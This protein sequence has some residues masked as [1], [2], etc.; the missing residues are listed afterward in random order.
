MN[1]TCQLNLKLLEK[2]KKKLYDITFRIKNL[3]GD[4]PADCNYNAP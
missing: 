1:K 3:T 4:A 2:K